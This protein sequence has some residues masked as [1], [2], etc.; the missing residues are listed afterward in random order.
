[1][2]SI[3]AEEG[4]AHDPLAALTALERRFDGPIPET[5]R[6]IARLGSAAALRRLQAEGQAEFFSSL[7]RSQLRAIRRGREAGRLAPGLLS[8]LALYRRERRRWRRVARLA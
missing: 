3:A 4:V 6:L 5:L 1:L 8:D 2:L 7:A